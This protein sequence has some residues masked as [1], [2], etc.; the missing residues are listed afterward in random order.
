MA[1]LKTRITVVGIA[2]D[3]GPVANTLS[4]E[5]KVTPSSYD[6][7]VSVAGV[8]RS[9]S[10]TGMTNGSPEVIDLR[11]AGFA[12]IHYLFV[13]NRSQ[14]GDITA[15]LSASSGDVVLPVKAG[16]VALLA[17]KSDQYFIAASGGPLTIDGPAGA[18][19]EVAVSGAASGT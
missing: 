4:D 3:G 11:S 8:G 5:L 13:A 14:T 1:D 9:M 17:S 6:A 10:K 2:H 16:G 15:T 19:Y 18:Q 12:S 7:V